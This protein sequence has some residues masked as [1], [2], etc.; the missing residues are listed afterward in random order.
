MREETSTEKPSRCRASIRPPSMILIIWPTACLG[1][2]LPNP[3][4]SD[5]LDQV[6]LSK[7]F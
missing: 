2:E 5:L 4:V 7:R 1:V 3:V 6:G